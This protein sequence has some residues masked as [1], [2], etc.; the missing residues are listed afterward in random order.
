ME[1]EENKGLTNKRASED[2]FMDFSRFWGGALSPFS[3]THKGFFE[4]YSIGGRKAKEGQ[5]S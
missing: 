2:Q 3:V 4:H 5:E 1:N